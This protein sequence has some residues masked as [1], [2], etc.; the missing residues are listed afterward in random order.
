MTDGLT[1]QFRGGWYTIKK[2]PT[3]TISRTANEKGDQTEYHEETGRENNDNKTEN[4]THFL[5]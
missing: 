1:Q 2:L 4:E 5:R 3:L